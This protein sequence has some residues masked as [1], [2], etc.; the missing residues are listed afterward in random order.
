MAEQQVGAFDGV[1]DESA[2]KLLMVNVITAYTLAWLD[3]VTALADAG[4]ADL[5]RF[6]SLNGDMLTPQPSAF[7]QTDYTSQ[8]LQSSNIVWSTSLQNVTTAESEAAIADLF[9]NGL[10]GFWSSDSNPELINGLALPLMGQ[11]SP[12]DLTLEPVLEMVEYE[13]ICKTNMCRNVP[14]TVVVPPIIIPIRV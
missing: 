11:G 5:F 12:V 3:G 2:D 14:P 13:G 10:R 9:A 7:K 8:E 1:A 6:E 4:G